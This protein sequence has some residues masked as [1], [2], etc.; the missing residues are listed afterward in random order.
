MVILHSCL[1]YGLKAHL[2]LKSLVLDKEVRDFVAVSVPI[3]EITL[4]SL[5]GDT[6]LVVC[7]RVRNTDNIFMAVLVSQGQAP[8]TSVPIGVTKKKERTQE[9]F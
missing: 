4:T 1:G 7:E 3:G 9:K 8:R 2:Q 6:L 5:N